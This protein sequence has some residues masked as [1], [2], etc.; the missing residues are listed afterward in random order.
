M[1]FRYTPLLIGILVGIALGLLYGWVF[2]PVDIEKPSPD[3][4]QEAYRTEIILMIA[5]VYASDAYIERALQQMEIF[6]FLPEGESVVKA[7]N[8]AKAHDFSN[9]EIELMTTFL[10]DLRKSKSTSEID[11]P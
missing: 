9:Q 3:S 7:L 4:L 1:N 10:T 5:E 11:S 6:G 2:Q 8:F